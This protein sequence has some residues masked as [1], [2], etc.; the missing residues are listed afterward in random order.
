MRMGEA[1]EAC[2]SC[3]TGVAQ[4]RA[5]TSHQGLSSDRLQG[6]VCMCVCW[7]HDVL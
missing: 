6:Y 2:T 4:G 1:P 5:P 7:S 3:L